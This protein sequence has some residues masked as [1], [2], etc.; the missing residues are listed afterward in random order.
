MTFRYLTKREA[1]DWAGMT[2]HRW[3]S[4]QRWRN[5]W[6]GDLARDAIPDARKWSKRRAVTPRTLFRRIRDAGGCQEALEACM[7]ARREYQFACRALDPETH[8]DA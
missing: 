1:I 2:F 7:A 6:I 5:D 8:G 3:L 4:H